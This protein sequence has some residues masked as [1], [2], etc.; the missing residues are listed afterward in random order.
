MSFQSYTGPASNFPAKSTWK[1]FTTLFNINKPTM[2]QTG[3]SSQDVGRIYNAIV[4]AAKIGVEERVILCIIMQESRGNVGVNGPTNQD[5]KVTGGLMQA[6]ES[7]G[8][9]GQ[10]NLSQVCL[11]LSPFTPPRVFSPPTGPLSLFAPKRPS[12]YFT[13]K[14]S[15]V[16]LRVIIR[17]QAQIS[18]MVQAGTNHY[19]GD[20]K[21]LDDADTASTIYR[22]LRLY[23]SGSINES[24]LSDGKG[25]T[26]SYVSDI[27]NRLQ[28]RTN[29]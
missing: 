9:P 2:L 25:A 8:F 29:G 23:N 12:E 28:G 5:G 16:R 26:P 24:N 3:D 19:K 17:I 10:H 20:L 21:Q 11:D 4:D 7:P 18:S 13:S 6:V 1:D 14:H 15:T 27:A 22:A